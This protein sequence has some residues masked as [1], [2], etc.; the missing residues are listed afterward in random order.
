LV[1]DA[2]AAVGTVI[3]HMLEIEVPESAAPGP[4]N[5]SISW[6]AAAQ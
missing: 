4:L 5:A 6:Q 2:R 3:V 1:I